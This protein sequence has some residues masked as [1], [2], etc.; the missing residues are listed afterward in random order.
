MKRSIRRK[1]FG[2]ILGLFASGL[3]SIAIGKA[4]LEFGISIL[5]GFAII[6]TGFLA[7]AI[8]LPRR[9]LTR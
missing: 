4:V 2:A 8:T 1:I 9:L 6:G 7:A 5:T 3:L